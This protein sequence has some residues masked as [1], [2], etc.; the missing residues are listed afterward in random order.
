MIK[1]EFRKLAVTL[2]AAAMAFSLSACGKKDKETPETTEA[3]TEATT[4][5]S[6]EATTTEAAS[7]TEATTEATTETTTEAAASGNLAEDFFNGKVSIRFSDTVTT[8]VDYGSI[9]KKEFANETEFLDNIKTSSSLS[10]FSSAKISK[11]NYKLSGGNVNAYLLKYDMNIEVETYSL[12]YIAVEKDGGLEI[13]FADAMWSRKDVKVTEKGLVTSFGSGGAG[14]HVGEAYV[15]DANFNYT[16]LY[17]ES[18]AYPGYSFYDVNDDK[19]AT[20]NN[21]IS[22][23]T[24]EYGDS[25]EL[26]YFGQ[27]IMGSNTYYYFLGDSITQEKVDQIDAIASK[28]NFTFDGYST[29][30]EKIDETLKSLG[31]EDVYKDMTSTLY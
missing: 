23:Y 5:A 21:I 20:V 1:K 27:T 15:P 16:L 19:E 12:L 22:D 10:D 9:D 14:F 7:E 30:E 11:E 26:V 31:A 2:L 13:T 8:S 29:V 28:Y 3:V 25:E 18:Q 4:E 6:T 17:R 24:S